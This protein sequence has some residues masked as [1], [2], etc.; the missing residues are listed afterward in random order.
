MQRSVSC[1]AFAFLI[2]GVSRVDPH[3]EGSGIGFR[4]IIFPGVAAFWPFLLGGGFEFGHDQAAAARAWGN[5]VDAPDPPVYRSRDSAG[6]PANSQLIGSLE[7]GHRAALPL[8]GSRRGYLWLRRMS[9]FSLN[10]RLQGGQRE[11]P[12]EALA[13]DE[14]RRRRIHTDLFSLAHLLLNCLL[15]WRGIEIRLEAGHVKAYPPG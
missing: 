6:M 4:S 11:S 12:V 14:E 7:R 2:R 1:L 15:D 8:P 9:Q 3:A 10:H 13:I 5:A